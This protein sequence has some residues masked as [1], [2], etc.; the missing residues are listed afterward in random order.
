MRLTTLVLVTALCGGR[1]RCGRGDE[2]R[3]VLA[4][5]VTDISAGAESYAQERPALSGAQLLAVLLADPDLGP[6][7]RELGRYQVKLLARGGHVVVLLCC[8]DGSRALLE[9]SAC[10]PAVD[11]DESAAPGRAC[12]FSIDPVAACARVSPAAIRGR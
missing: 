9:D 4:R 2:A 1:E 10:T 8:E 6:Q 3:A 12:G 7:V 11:R 5:Q